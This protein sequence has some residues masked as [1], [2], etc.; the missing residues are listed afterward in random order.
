[1]TSLEHTIEEY[2]PPYRGDT[3]SFV[4]VMELEVHKET[5]TECR[6][7]YHNA[8]ELPLDDPAG[9]EG[10][11]IDPYKLLKQLIQDGVVGKLACKKEE[12]LFQNLIFTI[13][14][15]D[16]GGKRNA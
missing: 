14:R 3:S 5:P 8:K 1:M 7:V 13:Y 11:D 2:L 6:V 12:G 15:T 4:R 16:L 9:L 10:K